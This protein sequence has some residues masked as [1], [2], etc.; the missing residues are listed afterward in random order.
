M[1]YLARRANG[2]APE[3]IEPKFLKATAEAMAEMVNLLELM[4]ARFACSHRSTP[5][6]IAAG[7][8]RCHAVYKVEAI[9]Q[10][11]QEDQM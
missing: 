4:V 6:G 10:F 9:M 1:R 8:P 11:S 7:C 5:D 2:R 3:K